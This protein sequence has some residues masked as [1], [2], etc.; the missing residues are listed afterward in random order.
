[1]MK[2]IIMPGPAFCAAAAVRTK[3]PVPMMAPAQQGELDGTKR[4][5]QRFLFGCR[6]N[7]VEWFDA[8][9]H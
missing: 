8:S 6:Q 1:M 5:V 2:L 4:T 7:S 3:I 9:K